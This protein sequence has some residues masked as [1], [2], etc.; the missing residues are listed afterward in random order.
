MFLENEFGN[1]DSR[2]RQ[3][4]SQYEIEDEELGEEVV[5][6]LIN[7]CHSVYAT[8]RSDEEIANKE[9]RHSCQG[10]FGLSL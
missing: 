4:G 5:Q 8:H 1:K 9:Y 3:P 2:D 7:T 6:L 10:S